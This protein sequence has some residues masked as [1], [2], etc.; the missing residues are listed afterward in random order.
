MTALHK[1]KQH[2]LDSKRNS[3]SAYSPNPYTFLCIHYALQW[4]LWRSHLYFSNHDALFLALFPAGNE[5]TLFHNV[6]PLEKS[7]P[8]QKVL[9]GHDFP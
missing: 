2:I 9:H 7:M 6:N 4:L 3:I 5:A 8:I 1:L